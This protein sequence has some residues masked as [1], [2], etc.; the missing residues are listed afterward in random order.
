[1]RFVNKKNTTIC[2]RILE[3]HQRHT[4]E[5]KRYQGLLIH[6]SA[7]LDIAPNQHVRNSS[8][9]LVYKARSSK[10]SSASL[11]HIPDWAY[12]MQLYRLLAAP[13]IAK[14]VPQQRQARFN[15]FDCHYV[16]AS[17]RSRRHHLLFVVYA[18]KYTDDFIYSFAL[19][20]AEALKFF[21]PRS[22]YR[23]PS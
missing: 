7:L 11:Q 20:S 15:D 6:S 2:K 17:A 10:F 21:C 22:K 12:E 16:L 23:C 4:L 5:L 1:V 13:I 8:Y 9:S 18:L 3:N 14:H 19:V